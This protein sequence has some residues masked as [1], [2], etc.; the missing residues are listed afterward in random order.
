MDKY[1]IGYGVF[2]KN[3]PY[4]DLAISPIYANKKDAM[5]IVERINKIVCLDEDAIAMLLEQKEPKAFIK[6]YK[7]MFFM[8]SNGKEGSAV[9]DAVK[10][11]E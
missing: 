3:S 5:D 6:E 7:I 4:E 9:L 1:E 2:R 8:R 10:P 11:N